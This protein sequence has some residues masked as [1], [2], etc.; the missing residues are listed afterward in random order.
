MRGSPFFGAPGGDSGL[1]P[2]SRHPR[3]GQ[4]I[5]FRRVTF[6]VSDPSRPPAVDALSLEQT[7]PV[8]P[9]GGGTEISM[10]NDLAYGVFRRV[11]DRKKSK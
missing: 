4:V 10:E 3:D 6:R 5:P 7:V 9:V 11:F 8:Q 2:F 1:F